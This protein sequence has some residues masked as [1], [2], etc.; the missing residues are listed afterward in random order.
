MERV[1]WVM[2]ALVLFGSLAGAGGAGVVSWSQVQGPRGLLTLE[3]ERI[4]HREADATITARL[5][6]AESGQV[7]LRVGGGWFDAVDL[8]G[9]VPE[10]EQQIATADG[11]VL[12][13]RVEGPA[14][15]A[16]DISFR[17]IQ[18]GLLT[19][20]IGFGDETVTFQQLV[21]A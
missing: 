7:S 4:E 21:L 15:V 10:P 18:A 5:R 14:D 2:L 20:E 17:A 6:V 9:V 11:V 3:Y 1:G 13:V 8:R 19:G 16:V 12:V